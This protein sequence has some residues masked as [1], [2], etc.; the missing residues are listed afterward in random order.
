MFLLLSKGLLSSFCN[1][2]HTFSKSSKIHI[3]CDSSFISDWFDMFSKY[4]QAGLG[5]IYFLDSL[6]TYVDLST[7]IKYSFY[8]NV[9]PL[10]EKVVEDL[11]HELCLHGRMCTPDPTDIWVVVD[12]A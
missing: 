12:T 10:L 9:I 7:L 6:L 11:V 5:L 1:M 2:G 3:V 8:S 4:L